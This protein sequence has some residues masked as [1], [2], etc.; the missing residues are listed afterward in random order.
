MFFNKSQDDFQDARD[1][2]VGE[3]IPSTID[4]LRRG[5]ELRGLIARQLWACRQIDDLGF[6]LLGKNVKLKWRAFV[7]RLTP[8]CVAL[9]KLINFFANMEWLHFLLFRMRT[10]S[11]SDSHKVHQYKC[12]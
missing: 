11:I 8:V 2:A 9:M 4:N 6:I 3:G 5:D 1:D 10:T 7:E 12:C